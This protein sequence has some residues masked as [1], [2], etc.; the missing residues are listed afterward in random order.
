M[1]KV[2]QIARCFRGAGAD[3]QGRLGLGRCF[4]GAGGTHCFHGDGCA[5]PNWQGGFRGAGADDRTVRVKEM[6]YLQLREED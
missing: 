2:L 5:N 1:E 4:H 6:N 3:R